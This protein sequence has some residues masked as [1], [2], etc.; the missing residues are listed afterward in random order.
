MA[1]SLRTVRRSALTIAIGALLA[2]GARAQTTGAALD[3]ILTTLTEAN[4]TTPTQNLMA[5][6]HGTPLE[7][8]PALEA[9]MLALLQNPTTTLEGKR[10]AC[11]AL[12][13]IGSDAC[14]PVL[15]P[16]LSDPELGHM[17]R[18]A[19]AEMPGEQATEALIAALKQ[20]QGA[21]RIGLIVALG[22]RKEQSAT[23]PLRRLT[24]DKDSATAE[25]ALFSLTEIDP[26]AAKKS[27][28]RANV[29]Q[30]ARERTLLAAAN[31]EILQVRM[32]SLGG[33]DLIESANETLEGL[34]DDD[35]V[36]TATRVAAVRTYAELGPQ[37][38]LPVMRTL[39]AGSD[40]TMARAAARTAYVLEG[41]GLAAEMANWLPELPVASR[42]LVIES[43]SQRG[44]VTAQPA[45]LEQLNAPEPEVR[46]AALAALGNCGD[47][48]AVAP[49]LE[50]AAADADRAEANYKTLTL[51]H[52]PA[53]DERL[54]E[55]A[56]AAEPAERTRLLSV[57]EQRMAVASI[58][59][60]KQLAADAD[61][62]KAR[63]GWHALGEVAPAAEIEPLVASFVTLD[64]A[65]LQPAAAQAL[66]T[67]GKR[68]A[69]ADALMT[70]LLAAYATADTPLRIRLLDVM[71]KAGGERIF[72]AITEAVASSDPELK[73][74]GVRALTNWPGNE[75]APGLLQL[76]TSA[77]L[78]KHKILALQG[79]LRLAGDVTTG[80]TPAESLAMLR[81]AQPLVQR[82]DEK[83]LLL[84]ALG[85]V[86]DPDAM[87]MALPYLD[88]PAVNAEAGAAVA[89]TAVHARGPVPDEA[90]AAL[91]AVVAKC[92]DENMQKYAR[93]RLA[94]M[95]SK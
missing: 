21:M 61:D 75:A 44:D 32:M 93:D 79:Y 2:L 81:N 68:G 64:R 36:T 86:V 26:I 43:L 84:G 85:S 19:L 58:P 6:V 3:S 7:A 55:L 11:R 72:G 54:T 82:D 78:P 24:R 62:A 60:F 94:E 16:L 57:L 38:A 65:P 8:Y 49:L 69:N 18:F 10:S 15:A 48:N 83:R 51:L 1:S 37:Q 87:R 33:E 67:A 47:V 45:L 27:L 52:G 23:R 14:V 4:R 77:E 9:R 63:Q 50:I 80:R 76:A 95:E 91:Q 29:S 5:E 59:A 53:V 22:Q 92:T 41:E 73:D 12:R 71:G 17:A 35:G 66:V 90:R 20:T 56:L 46:A 74:A 42:L 70:A 39:L 28:R 31:H 30:A 89:Y 34:L 13:Q 40:Q 25:A 88:D